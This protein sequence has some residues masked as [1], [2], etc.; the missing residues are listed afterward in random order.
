MHDR[1]DPRQRLA[2]AQ[3]F[4]RL[5]EVRHICLEERDGSFR[6]RRLRGGDEIDVQDLVAL[7]V[8][9]AHD[10]TPGL[11]ATSCD[12]DLGH[13][14]SVLPSRRRR[15][16]WSTRWRRSGALTRGGGWPG[17]RGGG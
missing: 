14:V 1:L 2:S 5:A 13:L 3:R 17:G 12:R 9:R 15:A 8:Q 4:K 6:V 7:L 10:H 11:A 16:A